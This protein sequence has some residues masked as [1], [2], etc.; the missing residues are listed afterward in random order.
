MNKSLKFSYDDRLDPQFQKAV[1]EVFGEILHQEL[2]I[3]SVNEALN[4]LSRSNQALL[5]KISHFLNSYEAHFKRLSEEFGHL[6]QFRLIALYSAMESVV[7]SSVSFYENSVPKVKVFLRN[8]LTTV[9]KRSLL[10]Q[11]TIM[12]YR[13]RPKL[14]RDF[15]DL[16]DWIAENRNGFVHRS[17]LM[18]F[19]DPSSIG[20]LSHLKKKGLYKGVVDVQISLDGFSDLVKKAIVRYLFNRRRKPKQDLRLYKR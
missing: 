16:I 9:E 18:Y 2:N 4:K 8:N 20:T 19:N 11:F 14:G 5:I 10:D 15:D 7:G 6:E 1:E 13:A 17:E 12:S 3:N